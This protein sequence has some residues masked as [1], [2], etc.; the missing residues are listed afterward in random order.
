MTDGKIQIIDADDYIIEHGRDSWYQHEM[1]KGKD[2]M[3]ILDK[4]HEDRDTWDV[5]LY[6][7]VG[8]V[9]STDDEFASYCIVYDH[10]CARGKHVVFQRM[11]GQF[12]ETF[13]N[14]WKSESGTSN[15]RL[16][17]IEELGRF[18]NNWFFRDFAKAI[19]DENRAAGGE[20]T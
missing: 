1:L 10:E 19:S 11:L 2:A 16:F 5:N 3:N 6:R 7:V 18:H 4:L 17:K 14:R 9:D 13:M 12:V 15:V 8:K 20:R